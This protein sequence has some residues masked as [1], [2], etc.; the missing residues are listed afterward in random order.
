MSESIFTLSHGSTAVLVSVPHTGTLI[1]ESLRPAFLDGALAVEDTD[2]HLDALYAFARSLGIGLLVPRYSRYV[3][4]LNR[5]PQNEPMYAGRNNT[6]LVPTRSFSGMALYRDGE[7]PGPAEI[8]RRLGMYWQPYHDALATELERIRAEH[9]FAVLWDGHSI[10]SQL[11]WLFEGT[12]PDLNLGTAR[13]ASCSPALS[14]RLSPVLQAQ[15]RFTHAVDGRFSGGYIT[16]HYGR[17]RDGIHAVQ[18]EM[19]W[20]CYMIEKPPFAVDPAR[21]AALS[22]VLRALLEAAVAW[23]PH[24]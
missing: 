19:C 16:R 22:P 1:P 9:G 21:A 11:P 7:V 13:G 6:E 18:L 17:P 24:D 14:A 20:S 3:I 4:D 15:S 12:L 5:P 8:A 10:K 2:W 23:R